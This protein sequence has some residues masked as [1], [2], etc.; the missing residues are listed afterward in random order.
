LINSEDRGSEIEET[1]TGRVLVLDNRIS[2][3]NMAVHVTAGSITLHA[4][5]KE[6]EKYSVP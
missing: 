1:R 6:F 4:A 2:T 3:H 5:I